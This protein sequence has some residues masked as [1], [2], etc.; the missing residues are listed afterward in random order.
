VGGP[1]TAER[2][3]PEVEAT[4]YHVIT[5]AVRRGGDATVRAERADG[6]LCVSV[7][8]A[9]PPR[10]Q[11]VDLDDRVGALGGALRVDAARLV[12]ELPCG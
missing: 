5:E 12:A 9:L 4:A 3:A 7:D 10:D 11:L 2:F 1:L 8:A 6:R